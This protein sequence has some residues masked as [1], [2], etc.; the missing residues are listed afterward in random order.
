MI[1]N[2]NTKKLLKA[3]VSTSDGETTY[4]GDFA[5]DG[6][7]GT[8]A[9]ILLDYS[10]TAGAATGK[11]LPTGNPVDVV[12]IPMIGKIEMSVVDAGNPL[13]FIMPDVLNLSGTEGPVDKN[14][15]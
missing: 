3:H 6:V 11:L 7:P 5:I 13:C 9:K 10:A 2:T 8:S 1:Y 14:I 12:D 4:I 15:I